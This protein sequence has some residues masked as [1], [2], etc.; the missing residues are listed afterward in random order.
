MIVASSCERQP[1]RLFDVAVVH[2]GTP[3]M[4]TPLGGPVATLLMFVPLVAIP[5]FAVFGTPQISTTGSP[6]TQVEDLKFAVDKDKP[7]PNNLPPETDLMSEVQVSDG[8]AAPRNATAR[9]ATA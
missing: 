8:S 7:S 9:N 3:R 1:G 6:A 2:G 4:R 5:L